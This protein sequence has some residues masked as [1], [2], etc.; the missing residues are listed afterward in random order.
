MSSD[1]QMFIVLILQP[2]PNLPRYLKPQQVYKIECDNYV[3]HE[4]VVEDEKTWPSYDQL[5]LNETQYEAFKLALTHEFA[6][7]QGP[8][9]TGKTFIGVKVATTCIKNLK[10]GMNKC[11]LLMICYTNHALD[12]FLEAILPVTESVARIGGQSRSE[13]M[14]KYNIN[15][16]RHN[17]C[18]QIHGN[19]YFY[20]ERNK[21]RMLNKKLKEAQERLHSLH[22][23]VLSYT[24]VQKH[25]PEIGVLKRF[26]GG[27]NKDPLEQWLFEHADVDAELTEA[28]ENEN[29]YFEINNEP[30]NNR[31]EF[32][33]DDLDDDNDEFNIDN[34]PLAYVSTSFSLPNAIS[35]MRNMQH[36]CMTCK[37]PQETQALNTKIRS[38]N[39]HIHL[40]RV[41]IFF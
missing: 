39:S 36:Q 2:I 10:S 26:Y 13:I 9:G 41:S 17:F 8:P 14:K 29:E 6:V 38:Y 15:E 28:N 20:D 30:K 22:N 40:F 4:F 25:V 11:L 23:E 12:Q 33:I 32:C 37:D 31:D 16:L 24:C 35:E 19:Q 34:E 7:I 27:G 18:K 1:V 3:D 5:G 21:L